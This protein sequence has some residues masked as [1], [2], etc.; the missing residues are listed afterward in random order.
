MPIPEMLPLKAFSAVQKVV[1]IRHT[2]RRNQKV[3]YFILRMHILQ[4]LNF[5]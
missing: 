3:M 2:K 4:E 1:V 5:I